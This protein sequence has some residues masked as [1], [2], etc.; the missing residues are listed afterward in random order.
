MP[1]VLLFITT[2]SCVRLTE[3]STVVTIVAFIYLFNQ[4]STCPVDYSRGRKMILFLGYHLQPVTPLC[5][6]D[7]KQDFHKLF[8]QLQGRLQS[9]VIFC[10]LALITF[11]CENTFIFK[12]TIP[13]RRIAYVSSIFISTR[14]TFVS[15]LP[16]NIKGHCTIYSC[17]QFIMQ[18]QETLSM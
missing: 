13:T 8:M 5:S 12:V 15:S 10:A 18:R 14:Y 11:Y 1:A 17:L 2:L 7:N 16:G 6:R 3:M 9:P 4:S